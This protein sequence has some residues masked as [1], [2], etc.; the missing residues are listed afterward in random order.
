MKQVWDLLH[1]DDMVDLIDLQIHD[2]EK[3]NG[4][5]Y[6]AGGGEKTS[7]SLLEMTSICEEI[8]GNKIAITA[9]KKNRPADLRIFISDTSKIEKAIN[10][11]P[12][13]S[14]HEI[15][16]DIFVWMKQHEKQLKDIFN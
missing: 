3:F 11:K 12:Q 4:K 7:A 16:N 6:N 1:I 13:K 14:V 10:W 2:I 8:T 15:F 5:V 9:E